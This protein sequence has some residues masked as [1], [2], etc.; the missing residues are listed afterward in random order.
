M[1]RRPRLFF[2]AETAIES[3]ATEAT[4]DDLI[5]VTTN[6]A[7]SFFWPD[8]MLL[9]THAIPLVRG[10][11]VVTQL[12]ITVPLR[13]TDHYRNAVET[14]QPLVRQLANRHLSCAGGISLIVASSD[15]GIG[16]VCA[17]RLPPGTLCVEINYCKS[18]TTVA[19]HFDEPTRRYVS[20]QAP[21]ALTTGATTL[22]AQFEKQ[23]ASEA[24]ICVWMSANERP[25]VPAGWQTHKQ[26]SHGT[27][28][29]CTIPC[30]MTGPYKKL[31]E[32]LAC[33]RTMTRVGLCRSEDDP[34]KLKACNV[35]VRYEVAPIDFMFDYVACYC[36]GVTL[37]PIPYTTHRWPSVKRWI[38]G[39]VLALT[40]TTGGLTSHVLLWLVNL[41]PGLLCFGELDKLRA[42]ETTQASIER[43]RQNR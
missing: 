22:V 8:H 27:C 2:V 11:T 17:E 26:E 20:L 35:P 36:A 31:S 29:R 19:V 18:Q 12:R 33:V 15:L 41:L 7:L 24:T 32:L 13:V 21:L 9:A 42:I 10:N 25:E 40:P 1:S 6:T 14:F 5:F 43:I 30:F 16:S 4:R 28:P 23:M 39:V 34:T 38:V 3:L 37:Q